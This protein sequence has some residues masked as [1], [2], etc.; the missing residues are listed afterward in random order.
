M[1]VSC[2]NS[3]HPVVSVEK[4]TEFSVAIYLSSDF[5]SFI[6]PVE[7]LEKSTK[8]FSFPYRIHEKLVFSHVIVHQAAVKK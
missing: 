3:N 4:R 1:V 8:P 2:L 5:N 7:H 6:S